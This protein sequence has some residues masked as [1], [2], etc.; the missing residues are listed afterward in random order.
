[1]KKCI[2]V[3]PQSSNSLLTNHYTL[4]NCHKPRSVSHWWAL[5]YRA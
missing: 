3:C 2:K 1:M 4:L 5:L